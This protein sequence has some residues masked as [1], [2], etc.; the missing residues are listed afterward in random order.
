MG[1]ILQCSYYKNYCINHNKILQSDRDPQILTVVVQ[2]CPKQIQ[3]GGRPPSW[4]IETILISSVLIDWFWQNLTYWC[5]ST[6]WTQISNKISRFQ[7]SKMA[8]T[9]ILKIRKIAISLQ[10]NDRFWQNLTQWCSW[11]RYI[12]SANKISRFR[13]S[14]IAV[15]A[16]LKNRKILIS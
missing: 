15:A 4:K 13:K 16:I 10:R 14:K 6:V 11:A 2:I 3:D 7:K 8:A 9:A 1:Q 12:P 5:D